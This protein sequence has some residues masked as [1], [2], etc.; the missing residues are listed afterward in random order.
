MSGAGLPPITIFLA[1][2]ALLAA[3][4]SGIVVYRWRKPQRY[5]RFRLKLTLT[6]ILFLL[7]P[8]VPLL[9][10]AGALM[11]EVRGLLVA[12]PFDDAL[13][14]GLDAVR[15]AL[16][17]E[18]ARLSV[19]R[20]QFAGSDAGEPASEGPDFTL[21]FE[22]TDPDG[23][24]TATGVRAIA[25]GPV[26]RDSLQ[27]VP[28]DPRIQVPEVIEETEFTGEERVLFEYRDSGVYMALVRLPEAE[29]VE[30]AG[31]WVDPR[32]VRARYGLG[33]GLEKFRALTMLSEQG[34]R[35]T[36]WIFASLWLVML[37]IGAF[38]ATRYLAGGV[39]GPVI[40]LARGMERVAGGDLGT[41]LD[42]QAKDEMAVLVA[43]FNTMTDQL[44]D[45][46][47]RI[48]AAEKQAAWQDVARRIA[49]EIKNPLTPLQLGLHRVQSRL[50]GEGIWETDLALR[51]S[52]QTM[53]EE[54]D[55]LRRLA[56]S[57]SEF[58]ELPRPRMEADDI[59]AIT[60]SAFALFQE[61]TDKVTLEMR[62]HGHIE[63]V[64]MD[65]ELVKRAVINLIKNAVE[66]VEDKGGGQVRVR[67]E[68]RGSTMFLEVQ[69][70]GI[71]F[72]PQTAEQLFH[73]EFTTKSKGTGLGL[74]V[75]ARIIA[76]HGWTIEAA[77]DGPGT[78][79][80]VLVHIPLGK[81]AVT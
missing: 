46:R 61:G 1:W 63:P 16:E 2:V 76:D 41:R 52:V 45:A 4:I 43:S 21:R 30:A 32:F 73:P 68:R 57:F 59:E 20:D 50:Q 80:T 51:D 38:W 58:A 66:A 81:D 64:T 44:K 70:N 33:D 24:W 79:A 19:W 25:A 12:L 31:I 37:T 18:D 28:P 6:L 23:E 67:L 36:V 22:R 8:T 27:S 53:S 77:S 40:E 72:D 3:V 48:V 17:D 56:A 11:D 49:H 42:T 74:S 62:V 29:D 14:S 39:S 15:T 55:A 47:E 9:L 10:V 13:E 71:G 7:V 34:L 75:V 65:A 26:E 60:R 69:D 5:S 78:G 54:V 35:E